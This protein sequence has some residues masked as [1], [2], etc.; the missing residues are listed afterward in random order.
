MVEE[1]FALLGDEPD[2]DALP[3]AATKSGT[4]IAVTALK[5]KLRRRPLR[6]FLLFVFVFTPKRLTDEGEQLSTGS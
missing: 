4:A 3:H 5:T 6:I 1:A 2:E